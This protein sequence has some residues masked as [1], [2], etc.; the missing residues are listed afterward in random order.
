MLALPPVTLV[1]I[2][3]LVQASAPSVQASAPSTASH[4][5]PSTPPSFGHSM[6]MLGYTLPSPI[7]PVALAPT[8][9]S[10]LL[11]EDAMIDDHI[12]DVENAW[13]SL[14]NAIMG[15]I[16]DSEEN[17]AIALSK[18]KS[19]ITSPYTGA[20]GLHPPAQDLWMP[21]LDDMHDIVQQWTD[22]DTMFQAINNLEFTFVNFV[23]WLHTLESP[24]DYYGQYNSC[25][26]STIIHTIA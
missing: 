5:P 8:F 15:A 16:V 10:I 6:S 7:V 14:Y 13:H 2:E 3:P 24:D 21:A 17:R 12:L 11:D 18:L 1:S 4:T 23:S 9:D 22:A 20:I 25:I 26:W 19:I